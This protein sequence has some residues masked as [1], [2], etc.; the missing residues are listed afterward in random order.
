MLD[1]NKKTDDWGSSEAT[2]DIKYENEVTPIH[3]LNF[4][5]V[6]LLSIAIIFILASITELVWPKNEVFETCKVILAPIATLVIGYYFGSSK[7]NSM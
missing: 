1:G 7:N 5:K 3:L 4:A 6:I 2:A